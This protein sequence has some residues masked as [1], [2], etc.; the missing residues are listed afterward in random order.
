MLPF[1]EY[2]HCGPADDAFDIRRSYRREST[3][4]PVSPAAMTGSFELT[5]LA[6]CFGRSAL[7]RDI[8]V[9]PPWEDVRRIRPAPPRP[10]S[11]SDP[12]EFRD[13]VATAVATAIDGHECLAVE[14]SGGGLACAA[15]LDITGRMCRR[16][17]QRLL[18]VTLDITDDL[19]HR[20]RPTVVRLLEHLGVDAELVVVGARPSRWPDP[21]WTPHGP[22]VDA[23]PRYQIGLSRS[24]QDRG[25]T[26]L[27]QS[28]GVDQLLQA[29]P[30]LTNE[31]IGDH[32]WKSLRQYRQDSQTPMVIE[33]LAA[34]GSI[35]G[36]VTASAH[37]S[38]TW[39]DA[40]GDR[41]AAVLA[42]HYAHRAHRWWAGFQRECLRISVAERASWAEATVM[43]QL[44]P[45]DLPLP[46]GD[47]ATTAPLL[48]PAFARYAYHL[49][50]RSR[51]SADQPNSYLRRHGLLAGLL[52]PGRTAALMPRSRFSKALRRYLQS[53]S[54]EP[55][56]SV[57]LGLLRSDWRSGCHDALDL[58][59]VLS[60][61][62]W[63]DGALQRGC[64]VR[65]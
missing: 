25:A 19:G 23:W 60:C 13:R 7:A 42:P 57:A 9:L 26:L 36:P 17:G 40:T 58:V 50:P 52:S 63:I 5:R 3:G 45:Y 34:A 49:P 44:F 47:I 2:Q 48:E 6:T 8:A 41:A 35:T 62:G 43:H 33:L 56:N 18:V 10:N 64:V 32:A 21:P 24:A 27:L 53:V 59:R 1:F 30:Y 39:P 22:R 46:A 16:S 31:L 29:P 4:Q 38:H 15:L 11:S 55:R 61:E 28:H 20:S 14:V 54:R 51:Y 37:W 65:N 12:R